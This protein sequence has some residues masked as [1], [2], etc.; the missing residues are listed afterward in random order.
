MS[1][2][3]SLALRQRSVTI[4][5]VILVLVGG[6]FTYR[7]LE[8]ELFPEIEFPNITIATFY[9]SANPEAVERDITEP[10]ENAIAGIRGLKDLQSTSSE[11]LSLVLVTF[12]FGTDMEEAERTISSKISSIQ[13][14]DGVKDSVV[15][16]I[17]P[18][19]FPVL[20]LSILGQ[21]DIP[22]LQRLVDDLIIPRIERVDGVSRVDVV[23]E[24]EEQVL[25]TVDT[26]KLEDLGL[27]LFQVSNAIR[28]NNLSLPAGGLTERGRT[29][30]VRTAHQF[31]SL[32]EI[33]HLVVGFEPV[34]ARGSTLAPLNPGGTSNQRPVRLKDIAEVSLST[35][36]AA[37]ISRTNG[38]P[39]LGL[40]II[41]EPDANTV[42]V[43][44]RVL[45]E[46]DRFKGLPPDVEI[47]T[48]FNDGPEVQSQLSSLLREGILGFFLA[49]AVVFAFLFT[50]RP[51][52][53]RGLALALRPT[54]VVGLSIPLSIVTGILLMGAVGL[55]LNFMTLAGLAIAVGRVVDDS[56]VVLEN[57]YRHIQ[58]GEER[59]QA[60]FE[61]T[62][63]V[64]GAITA[65]T[66]TTIVVFIPLAFIQGLVG[67]FFTPFTLA[68][69]FALIG[70]LL[71]A[72]TA[73]PVLGAI[74]LRRGDFPEAD[75]SARAVG[76]R[77]TWMQR[78]YT[79][80]LMWA[81]RHKLAALLIAFVLTVGSLGLTRV[82]PITFFPAGTPDFLTIDIELPSGAS[83]GRT[84]AQVLEAE[85]VL[86]QLAD[87]GIVAAYQSTI[88]GTG[89]FFVA[90]VRTGGLHRA[91]LLVRLGENPPEGIA[92]TIR[93]QLP[94]DADTTISVTEVQN[95]PPTDDLEIHI[96]GSNF[97][98]ISTV[99]KQLKAGLNSIDGIINVSSDVTEAR[100]EVVINIDPKKAA[101]VGLTTSMVGQ[102]VHQ[103]LVGRAVTQ[104]DLEGV[105]MDI[106]VRG[107]PEG[108]ERIDQVRAL[109]IEGSRGTVPLGFIA[110]VA[111]E[112]GPV[113]IGHVDGERSATITGNITA[114]DTQVVGRQVQAK[115]AALDLPPGVEVK[116]GGIFQQIAEGF[117]D[118]F[119]A[120]A[121]GVILV[122]LVMV[123][124]TGSLRNPLVI[125]TSL[126]LA[127]IGSLV[128]LVITGRTLSLSALMGFLLLIGIVVTNAI[129][130]IAFVE[131][132]RE[133]GLSLYDALVQGG[134][135]RLRPIL[136]TAFTTLIALIPLAV[137]TEDSSGIIGAELATVVIGGLVS[138][139]FLTLIV[140]P[141]VYT[142]MHVSLPGLFQ[143][144]KST[145][146]RAPLSR[147][148]V[149]SESDGD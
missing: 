99:A 79:P 57:M 55:S 15:S 111:V 40:A 116:T 104:V 96:T 68:V 89:D 113:S 31:G 38:K 45:A 108:L 94:G 72:L 83:V 132:L 122:Y 37:S 133:R 77:E 50:S 17:N 97:A 124:S 44:S 23:G 137:S 24:V 60:A 144:I 140:V 117:Q 6:V 35:A 28:E 29:F 13:F 149:A 74:F 148:A 32:E 70:S 36:E 66:L 88:G 69:N 76:D 61:A 42:E 10:I 25:V 20:Q 54:L 106:V 7:S 145:V 49:V 52:L 73:V 46:L 92:E 115:I 118:V 100:D 19:V 5:L 103:F 51:T 125:I 18:D 90:G 109:R 86:A 80:I 147:L 12:E 2:L 34:P 22:S 146:S 87:Q 21:R 139:T 3:T 48:I 63:E 101:E 121:A 11:N 141:V 33:R 136:M 75:D 26:D 107:Q 56:I 71:V 67:S 59:Q 119:L 65:S 9:P 8:R 105:S 98:A 95:G 30:A 138:S 126:P 91:T 39:S 53:L 82:I 27:S 142:T 62:R 64:A 81:L 84:F 1:F 129:V 130:L 128:A 78:L 135:V 85:K 102:Q 93:S 143:S 123:A 16:R 127:L 131:Q 120:M 41:K 110:D 114:R 14:P 43:T 134:R 112:K 47:A 58:R 4:L